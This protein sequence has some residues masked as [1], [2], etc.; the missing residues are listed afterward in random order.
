MELV[1]PHPSVDPQA[2]EPTFAIHPLVRLSIVSSNG[3]C[4]FCPNWLHWD[5]VIFQLGP[6]V[7]YRLVFY[8]LNARKSSQFSLAAGLPG[9]SLGSIHI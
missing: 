5:K 7:T 4:C 9:A 1:I 6:R 3:I 2:T 8:S